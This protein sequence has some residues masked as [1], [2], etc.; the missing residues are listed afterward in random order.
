MSDQINATLWPHGAP[1][2]QPRILIVDD[3]PVVIRLLHQVFAA[4][5]KVYMAT[6]GRQ[7]LALCHE[8]QPDLVLLDVDLPDISGPEVCRQI[9]ADPELRNLP[10]IFVTANDGGE[11][12]K[13]C[14]D[15][16][17]VD[18]ICKPI[19]P[20]TVRARVHVHVTLKF[21]AD[22]LR[23]M[24]FIDG[25]TGVANRRYFDERLE[26]EWKR[27][28]RTS[29]Q[30]A[31]AMI[32]IDHFKRYNDALGHQAGDACIQQVAACIRSQANRPYD[33]V[34]R[35]G[36]EEFVCILPETDLDGAG[37]VARLIEAAVRALRIPH[38]ASDVCTVVSVSVGFAMIQAG[39]TAQE[40]LARADACMY[41]AKQSGRGRV[42]PL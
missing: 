21:Q 31:V 17:G 4:D 27:A 12:E 28:Q 38:P 3:Q 23:R 7:A 34:A 42:C 32:D 11:A 10:V 36:G 9:K 29:T 30:L 5:Y 1:V 19:M 22:L 20:V 41:Q 13:L 35:Y 39:Q 25:L 26:T 24:V 40:L 16:G 8:V 33:L 18:F 37:R 15:A 14:W 2:R 6:S